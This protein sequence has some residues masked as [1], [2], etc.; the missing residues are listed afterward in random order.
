MSN[1]GLAL[2]GDWEDKVREKVSFNSKGLQ[3]KGWLYVPD[4]MQ[5]KKV[6][7]IV[8]AHG[9]SAVKEQSLLDYAS[10]F[11]AAGFATLVFDYRFFGESEGEPRCQLFPLEMVEDYRNAI[12]WLSDQPEVDADRIGIWGTSFS[13][14]YVLY[15]GS[16]DPRVK[17]V[18]AQV[19][20]VSGPR[21][22]FSRS[23]ERWQEDAMAMT[24]RRVERYRTGRVSYIKVV[25]PEGEACIIPGKSAYDFFVGSQEAAP[26]WRNHLTRESLEKMREF[27]PAGYVDLM[28]P[29]SLLLIAAERDE[30][31]PLDAVKQV[32]ER[33]ADPKGLEV[34]P[35]THFEIYYEP[36]LSKAAE[37]AIDWFKRY[38]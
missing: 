9:L 33:A 35:T 26:N 14:G 24:E 4:D 22:R 21:S 10:Q 7:A 38:L 11:A 19:P 28:A 25:A 2:S 5:G 34:L 29:T 3:C 30:L 18:V 36:W 32:Y 37:A 16:F 27:D 17:A 1:S 15:T 31:I 13:G 20:H 8:M 6:P 23:R 12:T